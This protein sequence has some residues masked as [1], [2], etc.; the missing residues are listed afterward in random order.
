MSEAGAASLHF[1]CMFDIKP[2]TELKAAWIRVTELIKKWIESKENSFQNHPISRMRHT[3]DWAYGGATVMTMS[4]VGEGCQDMPQYWALRYE[5]KDRDK[6]FR[7]WSTSIGIEVL[8]DR[9]IRLSMMLSHKIE[10]EYVGPE[11]PNPVPTAPKLVTAILEDNTI[12]VFAGTE[13][14]RAEV[15]PIKLG[16]ADL[17]KAR[18]VDQGRLCPILLV[19]LA[20]DTG[21]PLVDTNAIS[22]VLAGAASIYKPES[23]SIEQEIPYVLPKE[24]R[25][26]DGAVRIYF[27][28]LDMNDPDDHLKH[29]FVDK[30][31]IKKYGQR[32]VEE[33]LAS[34]VARRFRTGMLNPVTTVIDV[35]RI[36]TKTER[37]K[38]FR[39][40]LEKEQAGRKDAEQELKEYNNELLRLD[41]ENAEL[42]RQK[43]ELY[44][45]NLDLEDKIQKMQDAIG[46]RERRCGELEADLR[47]TQ[48]A[49]EVLNEL[50]KTV[51]DCV[52][53]IERLFPNR[54]SFTS[55]AKES[56]TKSC[57]N[58]QGPT[59]IAKAWKLIWAVAN[60]L[61]DLYFGDPPS[62]NIVRDFRERTGFDLALTE[63][64][65]TSGNKDCMRLRRDTYKGQEIDITSHAKYGDAPTKCLR[66][67]YYVSRDDGKIVVGHCGDHLDT[68]GTRRRN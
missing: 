42:T 11:L 37:E 67:H 47:K 34:A 9:L 21:N 41:E 7:R 64:S 36:Q 22:K 60:C 13:K 17:F 16:K 63:G 39:K 50:P 26:Y 43:N 59:E 62:G 23:M 24:Y 40:Y 45:K 48:E 27:P 30:H 3:S 14:L 38:T 52:K 31:E 19:S 25:C 4:Y 58:R 2:K 68:A 54:I 32:G 5:H 65:T 46:P 57:L 53:I 66:I 44:E 10:E 29:R 55:K 15:N 18:L 35:L 12:Q 49:F 56:A 6:R 8:C 28:K 1:K 33:I 51:N 20:S 61:Y